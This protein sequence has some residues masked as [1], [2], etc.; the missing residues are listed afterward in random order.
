MST[1]KLPER[2]DTPQR[3]TYLGKL[4]LR[5]ELVDHALDF[6]TCR[7]GRFSPEE[8]EGVHVLGLVRLFSR[9]DNHSAL[10]PHFYPVSDWKMCALRDEDRGQLCVSGAKDLVIERLYPLASA[11]IQKTI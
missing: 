1:T 9:L 4:F 5:P 2:N 10:D 8:F 6:S 3:P 7:T 11:C